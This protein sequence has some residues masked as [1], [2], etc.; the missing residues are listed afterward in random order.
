[1][2]PIW[3]IPSGSWRGYYTY[4]GRNH[5]VCQF[6]LRFDG[7]SV[8]G[9][10]VDDVGSYNIGG[11]YDA[12]NHSIS[13]VKQYRRGTRNQRGVLNEDNEGH[14]V[15]YTGRLVGQNLGAGFR[16]SWR[17]RNWGTNS[18]SACKK[19]KERST[20]VTVSSICGRP[21]RHGRQHRHKK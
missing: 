15:T 12:R 2:R 14:A 10:G 3:S 18:C 19:L 1:M 5:D 11:K 20:K 7:S 9:D 13:F 17:I 6:H 21:W 8:T 16:G 4:Q